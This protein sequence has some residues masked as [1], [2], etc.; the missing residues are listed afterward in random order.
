[1]TGHLS[2]EITAGLELFQEGG[3]EKGGEEQDGGPEQNIWGVGSMMATR[4]PNKLPMQADTV[5]QRDTQGKKGQTLWCARS[6]TH[7][8]GERLINA[9][10]FSVFA[11]VPKRLSA[12]GDKRVS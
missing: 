9:T 4:C 5:L 2:G 3:H 6:H 8:V 11:K 1:M 10:S 7:T 12:L